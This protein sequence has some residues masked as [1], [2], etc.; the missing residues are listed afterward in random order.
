[1]VG[2][3]QNRKELT[4]NT[5]FRSAPRKQK[6]LALRINSQCDLPKWKACSASKELQSLI[7]RTCTGTELIA[8]CLGSAASASGVPC[9]FGGQMLV[10]RQLFDPHSSTYTYLLGDRP[11][12]QAVLIDSVFEQVRR[13]VALLGELD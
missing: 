8:A 11:S 3:G 7:F 12:G 2:K 13:D 6:F 1:M 4:T 9:L 10:L 5:S